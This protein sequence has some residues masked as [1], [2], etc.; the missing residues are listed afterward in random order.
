LKITVATVCFNSVDGI[1]KTIESVVM[2][3]YK[4]I[5]YII[6]DGASTDGTLDIIKEYSDYNIKFVSER[7]RGLYD[8]MNK[9]ADCAQGEY[10]LYMNSGDIFADNSVVERIIPHLADEPD[11]LYGSV[12]RTKAAGDMVERYHGRNIEMKL[13]L[14]GKMMCHQS[15][16]TKTEIMQRYRFNLEYSITADYD[17]VM[18]L[19]HDRRRISYVDIVVSKVDNIEGLSSTISNMDKMREQDDKSLKSNFPGWYYLLWP[20]KQSVRTVKRIKERKMIDD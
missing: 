13:L 1:R 11:M 2:Q 19:L 7:D 12:I 20:A 18:R 15:M 10:I 5:E 14:Q 16:F 8:A 9:A 3:T 4:E 17:F 6:V